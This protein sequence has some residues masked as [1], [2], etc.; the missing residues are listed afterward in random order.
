MR[1]HLQIYECNK[2]GIKEFPAMNYEEGLSKSDDSIERC[3]RNN[4]NKK[5]WR[6][7][8]SPKVS[9]YVIQLHGSVNDVKAYK[10]NELFFVFCFP[11]LMLFRNLLVNLP[12]P[13]PILLVL[14]VWNCLISLQRIATPTKKSATP[15]LLL[16][17]LLL[18][19]HVQ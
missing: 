12:H 9:S 5:I 15:R 4:N 10:L 18:V 11:F 2:I 3:H 16:L 17:L 14:S 1:Y 13:R 8:V 6:R 7:A 19:Y